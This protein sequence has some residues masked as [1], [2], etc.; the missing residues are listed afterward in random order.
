MGSRGNPPVLC[1]NTPENHSTEPLYFVSRIFWFL[2][3]SHQVGRY[4]ILVPKPLCD[5]A[6]FSTPLSKRKKI[7]EKSKTGQPQQSTLLYPVVT[8]TAGG[9]T[10]PEAKDRR[11]PKTTR[12][13]RPPEAK[14]I[15]FSW[16]F[17]WNQ[18]WKNS[19]AQ[20]AAFFFHFDFNEIFYDFRLAAPGPSPG[21]AQI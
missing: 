11:K 7:I 18:K 15:C 9:Q 17:H 13:Q 5:W 3:K 10:S 2:W 20:G 6:S 4:W 12:G 19:W 14:G 16:K 1:L 21:P 8:K